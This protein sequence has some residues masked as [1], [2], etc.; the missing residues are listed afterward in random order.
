M[1][2]FEERGQALGAL[3]DVK[4]QAYGDSVGKSERLFKIF[5]EDYWREDLGG[6]LIKPEL[7]NHLLLQV[8][9]IDKQNRIFSN[10][11]GDL[12]NESPYQDIGG[13]SLIG[14]QKGA[15]NNA[16][17]QVNNGNV[18]NA[19]TVQTQETAQVNQ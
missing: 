14:S 11:S 2:T 4:Q 3:V 13:Y 18:N 17:P 19:G 6:Y 15:M 16:T 10:P 8:R 5:L 12:M 1:S 9:I 7:L